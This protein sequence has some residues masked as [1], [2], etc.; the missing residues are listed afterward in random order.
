MG[1]ET[2][3]ARAAK[4]KK[5]MKPIGTSSVRSHPSGSKKVDPITFIEENMK[6]VH[7]PHCDT[8]VVR[9]MVAQNGLGR[10]LVDNGTYEQM[11]IDALLE[12]S[13]EP[14]Y[15]FTGNC[16]TPKGVIHLTLTMEEE[17]LTADT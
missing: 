14:L 17:P 16:V 4:K 7:Y 12:P 6:G 3:R 2:Q 10:M 13:T 9:A 11:K 15:N 5:F 1:Q 8:L